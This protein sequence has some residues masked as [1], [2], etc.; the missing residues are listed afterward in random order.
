[1]PGLRP[2]PVVSFFVG[3]VKGKLSTFDFYASMSSAI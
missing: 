3:K 2:F 1:M